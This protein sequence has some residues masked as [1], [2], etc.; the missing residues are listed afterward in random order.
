MRYRI[1]TERVELFDVN[2]LIVM[3]VHLKNPVAF[4]DLS[5]AF[6]EAC[7]CHEIL[8]SRVVIEDSGEA[9]YVD[10]SE[11]QNSISVTDRSLKEILASDEKIRF[12]IEDGEYIRAYAS[13][14]KII[15]LMHHLGGDGKSLLYFI[16]TF[17]KCLTG[18]KC[19][20]VPFCHA[21][22]DSIPR[23]GKLPFYYNALI[24]I[25]NRR[26]VKQ[27]R[28]FTYADMNDSY[29]AFWNRKNTRVEIR[30]YEKDEL[31][32]LLK[33]AKDAGVSLTSYLIT[34]MTR[35]A[36]R[37]VDVGL[38][39]DARTDGN[40]CMGNQV[41]GTSITIDYD[42]DRSFGENA[43]KVQELLRKKLENDK[44]KFLALSF[45]GRLDPTLR[46][47]LNLERAGYY[48]SEFTSKVAEYLGFGS[49]IR[50]ISITNLTRADIPL[51]YGEHEIE[52]IVFI[53]PVVSYAKNV[54]GIVT[55]GDVMT[56]TRHIYDKCYSDEDDPYQ[57]LAVLDPD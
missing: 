14:D 34:K 39:A 27:R 25:W 49:K 7:S 21:T 24:R 23:G 46:D 22:L 45:M 2:V 50:D 54:I 51:V 38:A 55:T 16:E 41:T 4:N 42:E 1:N 18:T 5:S 35:E 29:E 31:E 48:H 33:S 15:F 8:N 13:S 9:F 56:V 19:D 12:R 32:R 20:R 3:Q 30:K 10:C 40:K 47:A 28:V 37:R 26:W 6:Y 57:D 11:P 17:M 52:D 44:R 43:K 53:P 36:G